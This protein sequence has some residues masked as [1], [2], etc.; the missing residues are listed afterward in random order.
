MAAMFDGPVPA[1]AFQPFSK[2]AAYALAAAACAARVFTADLGIGSAQVVQRGRLRLMWR[3]PVWE[4]GTPNDHRRALR[5]FARWPGLTI[6]TPEAPLS[7]LGLVPLVTPTTHAIWDLSGDPRARRDG[8]WRNRLVMAEGAGLMLRRDRPGALDRLLQR[9][10]VQRQARGYQ[11]LPADFSRALPSP[12]V[13]LWEWSHAGELAAAMCF[14]RHGTSAS[15]HLAWGTLA[16]RQAGVH[17]VMLW[18]AAIALRGQGVRWLDLGS[19]NTEAAMGL[20]RFKLGTGAEVKRLGA[21]LLVL[22]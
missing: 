12:D 21:T 22:P 14:V 3:G 7:G 17:P 9:E 5:R 1:Q 11:S 4:S 2:S 15:Y 18:R 6:A 10:G 13:Q 19:I 16:A 20:A 8:K